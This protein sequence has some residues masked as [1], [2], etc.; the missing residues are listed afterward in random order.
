MNINEIAKLAGVSRATVSRYL[1]DGYVSGEKRERIREVIERTG[2]KP[3][4]QA[5]M[6][7]TKR[8]KLIGVII[9]KINSDA[10]GRMVAGIGEALNRHGFMMILANTSND[11]REELKYLSLFKDNQVD[12]VIFI[13]TVFTK[14]HKEL[15]KEYKVPVVILGQRLPGF[16]CVYQDDYRAAKELMDKM[17]PS[18]SQVGYL[19][20]TQK[21]EAAGH[22][23][24]K[25]FEEAL[26]KCQCSCPPEW[27]RE[28]AFSMEAAYEQAK[29]LFQEAPDIDTVFCA[30]DTIAAGAITLLREKGKR[31]P[32]DVQLAGFGDTAMGKV[33]TP[34]LTT[35]HF[36]YKR[37]GIE[38]ADMLIEHLT[39]GETVCREVKMGFEIVEEGSVRTR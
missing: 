14:K 9:P 32:E 16:S 25:G 22:S 27:H 21:D 28:V 17:L 35:V 39:S 2:Y 26:K 12:G 7:R 1:N 18:A 24:K 15:L 4:A 33:L 37:S 6:L 36:Y 10:V 38:A 30:T 8:T 3:S 19:G 31:I 34:K 23:R 29:D 20:V 11:I 5:Q 13:G